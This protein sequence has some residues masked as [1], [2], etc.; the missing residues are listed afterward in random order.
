MRIA[1]IAL[2]ALALASAAGAQDTY[3]PPAKVNADDI[4]ILFVAGRY[5]TPVK[6]KRADGSEVDLEDSIQLKP[7][8]EAGA[9]KALKV[10]FFGIEVADARY[11][12]SPIERDL[13]DRR[14]TI[15]LHFRTRNR[16]DMGMADFRRAALAGPLTY[17][18]HRGELRVRTIGPDAPAE[19][20]VLQFDGG[21]ARMQLE[22][23]PDGT[24]GAKL[25]HQ[26]LAAHPPKPGQPDRRVFTF[27][28]YPREGEPFT[29][30]GIED[31][32]RW[33]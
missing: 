18:A 17:N 20:R 12:Y 31:D 7:A 6:C 11:C 23:V 28:F 32:R 4:A 5:I 26:F 2:F 24:D 8:P 10:T 21:D 27:R 13:V 19:P 29:F 22:N 25:V 33:R 14:G 30:I 9:G 16:P 3:Q 1:P 15:F